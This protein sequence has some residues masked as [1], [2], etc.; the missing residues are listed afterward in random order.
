REPRGAQHADRVLAERVGDV[1]QLALLEVPI[2]APR[3]DEPAAAVARHSVDR[4]IAPLEVL[5]DGDRRRGVEREA[6]IPRRDLALGSRERVLLAG[7]RV[8]EYGEILA[9]LLEAE[10]PHFLRPGPDDEPVPLA[11]SPAEKC[12]TNRPADFINFHSAR[13]YRRVSAW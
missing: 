10:R 13:S 12:V 2:S 3:I 6:G 1:P 5:L 8:Q 11:D 4:E 9:D 7:L